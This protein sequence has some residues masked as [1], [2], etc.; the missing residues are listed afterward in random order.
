M[1]DTS[2]RRGFEDTE[3]VGQPGDLGVDVKGTLNASGLARV[4][5]YVQAKRYKLGSKVGAGDV[6]KLRQVIPT[7]GQGAV[8]TTAGFQQKAYEVEARRASHASG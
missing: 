2:W 6:R 3:V 5:V 1:W 8:I 4:N 7:G